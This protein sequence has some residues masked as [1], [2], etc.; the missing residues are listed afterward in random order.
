VA[1]LPD[2]AAAH[3][4]QCEACAR[5]LGEA[6]P[7]TLRAGEALRDAAAPAADAVAAPAVVAA[8]PLP[9][10]AIGAAL[11]IAAIAA[12]PRLIARGPA[13]VGDIESA[14]R[15]LLVMAGVGRALLQ[16]G[17][18]AARGWMSAL[19]WLSAALFVVIGLVVARSARGQVSAEEGGR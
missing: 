5:A 16:S 17:A 6:A 9:L 14:G 18:L 1:I 7:L 12:A 15:A 3:A 11:A 2:E 8:R 4:D 19:P 13:L 10:A